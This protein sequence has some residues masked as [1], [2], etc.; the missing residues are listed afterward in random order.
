MP[1]VDWLS[2]VICA[3]S[4][5]NVTGEFEATSRRSMETVESVASMNLPEPLKRH[6]AGADG[7]FHS[8]AGWLSGEVAYQRYV[9]T[10]PVVDSKTVVKRTVSGM[11]KLSYTI[12]SEDEPVP[13]CVRR[14]R[15]GKGERNRLRR[16]AGGG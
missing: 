13:L 12:I 4:K 3:K 11:P 1:V 10:P 5:S 7:R 9:V 8:V 6:D 14:I 16:A 2:A 15:I